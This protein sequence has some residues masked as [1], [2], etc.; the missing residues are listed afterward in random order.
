M[1]SQFFAVK[2]APAGSIVGI[3]GLDEYV[4]KTATLSSHKECPNFTKVVGMSTGVVK[5]VIEADYL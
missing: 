2:E 5:V 1:G 4:L 3:S